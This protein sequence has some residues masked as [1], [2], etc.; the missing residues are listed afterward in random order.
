MHSQ[1]A[2]SRSGLGCGALVTLASVTALGFFPACGGGGVGGGVKGGGAG[3]SASG[4]APPTGGG[5][6]ASGTGGAQASASGGT[7][8]G[9][10]AGSSGSGGV[11]GVAGRAGST[12]TS[13]GGGAGTSAPGGGA[14]SGGTAGGPSSGRGGAPGGSDG[15][16]S[17]GG[18]GGSGGAG[19][20]G[21]PVT[22]TGPD[23]NIVTTQI[24]GTM[25]IAGKTV[26]AMGNDPG[27]LFLRPKGGGDAQVASIAD[28]SYKTRVIT[29]TYDVLFM[30]LTPLTDPQLP[31]NGLALITKDVTIDGAGTS[32]LNL[33]VPTGLVA[34]VFKLNGAPTPLLDSGRIYLSSANGNGASINA[35][36]TSGAFSVRVVTGTYD[37]YYG[38]PSVT[39]SLV[40]L[41]PSVRLASGITVSSAGTTTV[42]A[43]VPMVKVRGAITINGV[44][45][46]VSGSGEVRLRSALG[47]PDFLLASTTVGTFNQ[48]V[49]PGTYDVVYGQVSK[50]TAVPINRSGI[51]MKGVVIPAGTTA[52]LNVDVPAVTVSGALTLNGASVAGTSGMGLVQLSTPEGDLVTLGSLSSGT[53][54][55]LVVPGTYD[56][57]Y[58][59]AGASAAAAPRNTKVLLKSA[60]V[61]PAAGATL[62][63]DVP[64]AMVTGALTIN[65]AVVSSPDDE[66]QVFLR[67]PSGDATLGLTSAGTYAVPVV[68]GTYDV[69]YK[70]TTASALA[71]RNTSALLKTGVVVAATGKT[72]LNIDVPSVAAAGTIKIDGA[73]VTDMLDFGN[74]A[75][76]G[77]ATGDEIELVPTY[78]GAY[79]TRVVP[80]TY[81]VVYTVFDNRD[82]APIN[83]HTVFTCM[84]VK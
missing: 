46:S 64:S 47:G 50:G 23:L 55:A 63:I 34:G 9:G 41:T 76:R 66:G 42:D 4:G 49:V 14:T 80:G 84:T 52:T 59:G 19:S 57:Y 38:G 69:F 11:P 32:T 71:P 77:A 29:G 44:A 31:V 79:A 25:K 6:M 73:T 13:S 30:G 24:A 17:G 60:V 12:P 28:G 62:N 26:T 21:A 7:N 53:Y 15:A 68:S 51:V 65:G 1:R 16:G 45:G 82:R 54:S 67:G 39:S 33:D 74:L 37:L 81:D 2:G 8:S 22:C 35:G 48:P 40:P 5:G 58:A 56:I 78:A 3:R 75:L 83:H 18:V 61:V 20:G 70:A 36:E 43:D 10:G 27:W 72:T